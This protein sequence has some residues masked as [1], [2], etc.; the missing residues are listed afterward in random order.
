MYI[1]WYH[2][3]MNQILLDKALELKKEISNL[4]E[5]IE[6]ERLDKL[7][8]NDEEVMKLS[9]RK[10]ICATKFEDSLRHFGEGSN[11]AEKAQN[12]LYQAKLE[13]DNNPLV[14]SYNKQLIIVRKIYDRIN[15]EIFIPFK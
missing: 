12:D 14:K 7:L 8:S 2:K 15:E 10:D 9:Y 3:H 11:E 6:L 1:I 13:L 4:P 5:V